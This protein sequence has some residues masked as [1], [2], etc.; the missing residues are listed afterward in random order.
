[1]LSV[2]ILCHCVKQ[3][4][5]THMS[6]LSS[7][8]GNGG[9]LAKLSQSLTLYCGGRHGVA[10]ARLTSK[11]SGN[12]LRVSEIFIILGVYIVCFILIVFIVYIKIHEF[13]VQSFTKQISDAPVF[14]NKLK[15][16]FYL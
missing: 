2:W 3:S 7:S 14:K 1:V 9:N 4:T 11:Q 8:T 15:K 6:A 12:I 5:V 16:Y 13:L 10:S